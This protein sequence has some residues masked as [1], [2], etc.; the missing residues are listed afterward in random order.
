VLN[1]TLQRV[2]ADFVEM[3]VHQPG[4]ALEAA[5]SRRLTLVPFAALE[6]VSRD[7]AGSGL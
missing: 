3:A 4:D 2:G 1:G 7:T 6:M 5:R